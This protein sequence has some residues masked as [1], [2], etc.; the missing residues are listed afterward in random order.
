MCAA[1]G[2]ESAL[3]RP[4]TCTHASRPPARPFALSIAA[5]AVSQRHG[6]MLG[7]AAPQAA[8]LVSLGQEL[9]TRAADSAEL[10]GCTVL[11]EAYFFPWE[12][13]R[14]A[15]RVPFRTRISSFS[16]HPSASLATQRPMLGSVV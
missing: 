3:A 13:P 6:V 4:Y 7:S 2:L 10:I 1:S 8:L 11:R 12:L 5:A 14:E 16:L 15:M 9:F